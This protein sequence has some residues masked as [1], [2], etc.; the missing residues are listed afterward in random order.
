MFIQRFFVKINMIKIFRSKIF[1][2]ISIVVLFFVSVS[3]GK[4]VYRKYQIQ[5][6]INLME[7]EVSSLESKNHDLGKMLEYFKSDAFLE[8][9]ARKKLNLQKPEEKVVIFTEEVNKESVEMVAIQE[10]AISANNNEEVVELSNSE[11]WWNYFFEI[12]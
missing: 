1:L 2:V 9:E 4:E 7:E 11:K 6:E 10:E 5:K 3:F 8:T 12:N